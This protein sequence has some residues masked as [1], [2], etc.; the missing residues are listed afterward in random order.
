MVDVVR[1]R[2]INCGE[3]FEEKVLDNAEQEDARRNSEPT[4]EI[5]CP[6]CNRTDVRRGW[7]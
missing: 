1:F 5:Q 6:K 7:E 2:C 4:Y 3:R